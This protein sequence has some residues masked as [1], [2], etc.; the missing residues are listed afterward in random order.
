MLLP[1]FLETLQS[2]RNVARSQFIG[3]RLDLNINPPV[4]QNDLNVFVAF[5]DDPLHPGCSREQQACRAKQV[6]IEEAAMDCLDPNELFFVDDRN[7]INRE[8][9][10]AG[11]RGL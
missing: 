11:S 7:A 4:R 1:Y 9:F 2:A 8:N 5:D 10:A 6:L 3:T